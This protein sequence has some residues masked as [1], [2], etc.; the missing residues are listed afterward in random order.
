M[1]F[2]GRFRGVLNLTASSSSSAI[3]HSPVLSIRLNSTLTA[4]KL[5]VSGK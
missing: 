1:A 5:F 2:L 3:I 4:P